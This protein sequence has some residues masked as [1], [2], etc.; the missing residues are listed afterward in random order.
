MVAEMSEQKCHEWLLYNDRIYTWRCMVFGK[1]YWLAVGFCP[2]CGAKLEIDG[3]T[4]AMVPAV[5][6]EAVRET[7]L[8]GL[9][10]RVAGSKYIQPE[11]CNALVTLGLVSQDELTDAGR[12]ILSLLTGGLAGDDTRMVPRAKLEWLAAA[13]NHCANSQDSCVGCVMHPEWDGVGDVPDKACFGGIVSIIHAAL[14]A[15]I[16]AQPQPAAELVQV[17][18]VAVQMIEHID[19]KDANHD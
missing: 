6:P 12:T 19:A 17:A 5:T 4:T 16:A 10:E 18:A 11:D 2:T 8:W 14:S 13:L 1:E 3:S 15:I 7:R 9:L